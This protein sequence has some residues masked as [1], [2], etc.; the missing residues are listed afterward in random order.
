VGATARQCHLACVAGFDKSNARVAHGHQRHG[1][2]GASAPPVP[3]VREDVPQPGHSPHRR[4]AARGSRGDGCVL[5]PKPLAV[6]PVARATLALSGATHAT[7]SVTAA[8]L[9][10]APPHEEAERGY[11][12]GF[13]SSTRPPL[14]TS[15]PPLLA[16]PPAPAAL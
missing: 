8:D 11:G 2:R 5:P 15:L 12:T 13:L 1:V 6:A 4:V 10:L 16:A 14:S 9:N 7:D 3:G